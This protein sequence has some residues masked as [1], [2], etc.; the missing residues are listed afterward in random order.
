M[1][2]DDKFAA[3]ILLLCVFTLLGGFVIGMSFGESV[4]KAQFAKECTG[5]LFVY[6]NHIY[7]CENVGIK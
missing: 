3:N 7:T 6:E 1:D 4:G 5:K 2:K